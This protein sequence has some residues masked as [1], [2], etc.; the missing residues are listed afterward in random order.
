MATVDFSIEGFKYCEDCNTFVKKENFDFILQCCNDCKC[1]DD[2]ELEEDPYENDL[3][4][5]EEFR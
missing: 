1:E 5:L 2:D 3:E 4:D